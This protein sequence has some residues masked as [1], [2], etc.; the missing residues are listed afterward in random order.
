MR[1]A[2]SVKVGDWRVR[3]EKSGELSLQH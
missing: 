2:D 3:R 1:E